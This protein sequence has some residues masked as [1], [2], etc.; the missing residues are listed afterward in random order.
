MNCVDAAPIGR[1]RS[2][3]EWPYAGRV[4]ALITLSA[5]LRERE[6]ERGK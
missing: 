2:E 6:R 5:P 3:E 4:A 1:Q